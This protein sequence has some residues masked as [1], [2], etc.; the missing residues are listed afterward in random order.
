MKSNNS[1]Y[2]FFVA[3]ALLFWN[4]ISYYFLYAN[5]PIASSKANFIFY[6]IYSIAFLAGIVLIFL[7]QKNRLSET[8]KKVVFSFVF[9][10]I[11]F[12]AIVMLDGLVGL[13]I[14]KEAFHDKK[15]EGIIFEPNTQAR[16]QTTEFDFEA[17]IN[18]LGLRDKEVSIDKGN[19]YR[20][21]CVGDSFTFGWGVDIEDSWPSQLEIFFH[22]KGF[23]NIEVINCGQAGQY[24]HT[25][26]KYISNSVPLLKPDLV[27]VGVLQLD[28]LAQLFENNSNGSMAIPASDS[29]T[30]FKKTKHATMTFLRSSF[31]NIL[32]LTG[33]KATKTIDI[34]ASWKS[35]SNQFINGLNTLQNVR[36][37][38][39]DDTIQAMFKSGN[40]NPGLLEYYINFP[41]RT[42]I[43][44]NPASHATQFSIKEMDKDIKDMKTT[45]QENN[46]NVIFINLPVD[47]FIGHKVIRTPIDDILNPY[48]ENNNKI[49]S[50]Y[51]SIAGSNS[52]PYIE[53]TDYFKT[54]QN[55]TKYFFLFDGHPNEKGYFEIANYIGEQLIEKKLINNK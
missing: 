1:I 11:L 14:K 28:D 46:C 45:C 22:E 30:I 7:L 42:F 18:S 35:S 2:A 9:T 47:P 26:K 25:Y 13:V 48:F 33:D 5:T 10:G 44:N 50:I 20:I 24:T 19:K 51:K 16:Y 49:D 54:L 3:L 38:T 43:F 4:P 37:S 55:K 29:K 15:Q 34:K 6:W 17:N 31:I 53:L 32:T 52:L 40:L 36:F 23:D 21:L 8:T 41:D 39:F 12:A 27:L